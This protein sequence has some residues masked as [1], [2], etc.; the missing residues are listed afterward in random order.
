MA[1]WFNLAIGSMVGG[2]ARYLLAGFVHQ[3]FG[4]AFPYGTLMVNL[5]GCFLIGLLAALAEEKFLLG[6]DARIL[7][8]VG[9]CGAFT[10][11]STFIYETAHLVSAGETWRALANVL[12]SVILGF[13]VFKLGVSAAELL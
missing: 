7:L 5:I 9:F 12:L 10:T 2:Y 1:K 13:L 6:P 3:I 11:F 8:M 4:A